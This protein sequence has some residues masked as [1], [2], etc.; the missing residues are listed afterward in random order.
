MGLPLTPVIANYYIESYEQHTTSSAVKL[1]HWYRYTEGLL[2]VQTHGLVELHGFLKHLNSI[3]AKI[4]FSI[5]QNNTPPFLHIVVCR[6][7][8]NFLGYAVYRKLTHT[9]H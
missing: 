8:D 6:I 4:K 1:A 7:S 5:E 9:D 3:H 2:V